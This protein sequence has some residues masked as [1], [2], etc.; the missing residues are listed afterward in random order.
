MD[1]FSNKKRRIGKRGA[2]A[3]PA[4]GWSLSYLP[5]C[6]TCL[7]VG[8]RAKQQLNCMQNKLEDLCVP[9]SEALGAF[10]VPWCGSRFGSQPPEQGNSSLLLLEERRLQL[11]TPT[12]KLSFS[13][14]HFPDERAEF[15]VCSRGNQDIHV[16]DIWALELGAQEY[17]L[18]G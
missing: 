5:W 1:G 13:G 3:Q 15:V 12:G 9:S 6:S 2:C 14:F 8:G 4:T 10:W 18:W 7:P 17:A 16:T 11:S